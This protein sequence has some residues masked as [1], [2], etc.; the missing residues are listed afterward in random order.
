[1]LDGLGAFSRTIRAKAGQ[2]PCHH[3]DVAAQR[4][5][6]ASALK[7][8]LQLIRLASD[9]GRDTELYIQHHLIV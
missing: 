8:R 2:C 7:L 1:M 5:L 9:N 4:N 3:G 6:E